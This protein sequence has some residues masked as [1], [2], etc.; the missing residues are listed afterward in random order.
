[1]AVTYDVGTGVKLYG[2]GLVTASVPGTLETL[3][4]I[5]TFSGGNYFNGY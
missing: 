4:Q 5:G 2:T 3:Q 1:V